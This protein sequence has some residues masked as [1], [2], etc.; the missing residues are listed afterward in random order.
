MVIQKNFYVLLLLEKT[1]YF[2]IQI[3]ERKLYLNYIKIMLFRS[4]LLGVI[5]ILYSDF[6][7]V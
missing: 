6:I 2:R 3:H 4:Y 7:F 1:K 5:C